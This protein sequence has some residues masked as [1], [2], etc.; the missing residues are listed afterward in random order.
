MGASNAYP[1]F[2]NASKTLLSASCSGAFEIFFST[3]HGSRL[4]HWQEPWAPA[5]LLVWLVI[6]KVMTKSHQS[7]EISARRLY[8]L[9]L[10]G[11]HSSM[12]EGNTEYII[13]IYKYRKYKHI[14]GPFCGHCWFS[15]PDFSSEDVAGVL[16]H[17]HS[18]SQS[19]AL[20]RSPQYHLAGRLAL[21]E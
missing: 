3:K 4:V 7:T 16:L 21:V 11:F 19:A 9:I 1:A 18:A 17:E 15:P 6:L 13:Y 12:T 10:I 2:F 20:G 5:I 14:T 8:L